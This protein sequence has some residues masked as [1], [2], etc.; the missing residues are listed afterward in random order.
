MASLN[1]SRRQISSDKKHNLSLH[2]V[3]FSPSAVVLPPS[4]LQFSSSTMKQT[5]LF[6][7]NF[8][9]VFHFFRRKILWKKLF[10]LN[11]YK[12]ASTYK[13]QE[14]WHETHTPLWL[15]IRRIMFSQVKKHRSRFLLE[16]S[17]FFMCKHHLRSSDWLEL[18]CVWK[19]TT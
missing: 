6:H 10:L 12:A 5:K 19:F 9:D 8:Q 17:F 3:I 16:V 18:N 2:P 7:S 11:V 14:F 13:C 15:L 1:I 4:S